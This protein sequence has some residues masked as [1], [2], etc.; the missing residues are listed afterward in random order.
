MVDD[1]LNVL[2]CLVCVE[3][4]LVMSGSKMFRHESGSCDIGGVIFSN[5]ES[6]ELFASFL[7]DIF[8]YNCNNCAVETT[9][10]E[11]A[12]WNI[13]HAL[14]LNCLLK[15]CFEVLN[16]LLGLIIVMVPLRIVIFNKARV[17]S[18][19]MAGWEFF[20]LFALLIDDALQLG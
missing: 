2:E 11:E 7:H 18:P 4:M 17:W 3:S 12:E 19:I 15:H 10:K 13:R 14:V 6:M 1:L 16:S 5:T 9:A 8:Q 20:E